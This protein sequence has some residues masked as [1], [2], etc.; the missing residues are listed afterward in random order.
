VSEWDRGVEG[1]VEHDQWLVQVAGTLVKAKGVQ[2]CTKIAFDALNAA[3][4]GSIV[5]RAPIN[6]ESVV[7]G[8]AAACC[9]VIVGSKDIV[10][11]NVQRRL[12]SR[13]RIIAIYRRA[14]DPE[15]FRR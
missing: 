13:I 9:D 7:I 12:D 1:I 4:Q 2:L 5:G 3:I 11:E 8:Y 6:L 15:E 10:E 14:G